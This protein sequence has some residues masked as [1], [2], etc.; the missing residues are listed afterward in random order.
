MKRFHPARHEVIK[1]EVDILLEVGFIKE[2]QYPEWLSNV[3]VVRKKNGKWQVCV[4]YINLN[5]ACSK[6]TFPLPQI[7]QIVDATAGHELLSFLDAYLDYNQIPMYPSDEAKTAFITPYAMYCYRV[8]PFGLNNTGATYQC[9]MSRV[10][11]PLLGKTVVVYI[12]DIL[13]KSKAQRDHLNH[14]KEAFT[15]LRR[16]RL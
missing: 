2:I 3:V 5:D 15:L 10:F 1:Q 14:L 16:H 8:M 11:E 4:D 9:M 7:D 6:D 12:D 13:V